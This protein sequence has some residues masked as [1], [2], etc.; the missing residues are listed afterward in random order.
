[1]ISFLR[2]IRWPNLLIIVLTQYLLRYFL[3]MPWVQLALADWDFK[4]KLTDLDFFLL[5]LSTL[6]IAAAGYIINDY[7]DNYIDRINKPAKVIIGNT[8]KR[9]VGMALHVAL[10]LIG[11][12]L[13]FYVA[14]KA[15]MYKLGFIHIISTGLLWFY[16]T[17]FKKQL[18]IGNIIVALLAGLVPLIVALYE[19]PPLIYHYEGLRDM[20][21]ALF[22]ENPT[23]S[24]LLA[25][26]LNSMFYFIVMLS[27]FAF[28][29]TLVR[30]II[31]DAQDI[32]GDAQFGCRTLPITIGI[33]WTKYIVIFLIVI[34]MLILFYFQQE[35]YGSDK[36]SFYYFLFAL[37]I[38]FAFLIYKIIR[39]SDPVDFTFPS[40][41]T[42]LIMLMGILYT[43]VHYK[44]LVSNV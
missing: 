23:I 29:T 7:F 9:R 41:L 34:I 25:H 14:I 35:Q 21:S 30:E 38:P 31:K 3:L 43:L 20:Y 33:Q 39:A 17:T 16:S 27:V 13:G 8:V 5:V 6:C 26:N 40:H 42:K 36:L 18:L 2:L 24:Q 12:G 37:Q 15:G 22:E 32:Y 28:L 10:N 11:I 44:Y 1:M 4:L 19:I